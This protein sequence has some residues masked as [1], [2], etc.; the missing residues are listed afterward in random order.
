MPVQVKTKQRKK[1]TIKFNSYLVNGNILAEL[2]NLT[3]AEVAIYE[4]NMS[5]SLPI[6]SK[7]SRKVRCRRSTSSNAIK[8][9]ATERLVFLEGLLRSDKNLWRGCEISATILYD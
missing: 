3:G 1:E 2:L 8:L 5:Q 6:L 9:K 7:K 4:S